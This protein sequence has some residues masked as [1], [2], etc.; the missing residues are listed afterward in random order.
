MAQ[1]GKNTKEVRI[2]KTDESHFYDGEDLAE[3]NSFSQNLW[4]ISRSLID[5]IGLRGERTHYRLE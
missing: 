3:P 5:G 1:N 4:R 2:L